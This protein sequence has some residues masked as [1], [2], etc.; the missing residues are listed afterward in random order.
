M[1]FQ[2]ICKIFLYLRDIS[3]KSGIFTLHLFRNRKETGYFFVPCLFS[4]PSG[5]ICIVVI[6]TFFKKEFLLLLLWMLIM[7]T[8]QKCE[9]K[10]FFFKIVD[11]AFAF[12][13]KL[14][15]IYIGD[16][17]QKIFNGI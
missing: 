13:E 9:Y 6:T 12:M 11:I 5:L 3:Q 14:C 4:L 16:I 7:L 1:F 2:E 15:F 17:Y 8:T 10:T